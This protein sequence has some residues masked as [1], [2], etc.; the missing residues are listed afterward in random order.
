MAAILPALIGIGKINTKIRTQSPSHPI[1]MLFFVKEN[2]TL[3]SGKI[4]LPGTIAVMLE[5][6]FISH[7]VQ[8]FWFI[9]RICGSNK[10]CYD[11]SQID[12]IL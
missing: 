3:N 8:K 7:L 1:R 2:E 12:S 11:E 4:R 10:V 5:P 6:E 9:H